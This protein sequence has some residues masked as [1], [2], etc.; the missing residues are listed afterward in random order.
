MEFPAIITIAALLEYMFFA[1][2]VGTSRDKFGVAAPA[3]SGHPEWER[4]YRVQQNTVEQL[5]VFLPSLWLFSMLV[6][7]MVGAGVG[8]VFVIGRAMYYVGYV[9]DP[10]S[11]TTGFLI[12]FLA[13]VVLLLG[14]LGGTIKTML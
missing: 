11:R 8:A 5:V 7:P 14:A 2:R 12:G 4:M 1:F 6:N 9:K 3:T 13:N 10:G